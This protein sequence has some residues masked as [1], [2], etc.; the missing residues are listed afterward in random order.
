MNLRP[1]QCVV[2][3]VMVAAASLACA[4]PPTVSP[5]PVATATIVA[6]RS[7]PTSPTLQGRPAVEIEVQSPRAFPVRDEITVLR[8]GMQE[9]L[10]SR[11]SD[12]GDTHVLIFTL[13][14]EEFAATVD[15]ALVVVQ[16]GR[17]EQRD[18]W[19]LGRLNKA[20]RR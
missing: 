1:P 19:D 6:I 11:Y 15:G 7:I 2:G 14:P 4:S 16:Y 12:G 5:T 17:G 9:F 20:L 18:R 3:A 10:L 8:I 13:T